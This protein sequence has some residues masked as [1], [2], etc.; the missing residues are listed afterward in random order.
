MLK[1]NKLLLPAMATLAISTS[2]ITNPLVTV[3]QQTNKLNPLAPAIIIKYNNSNRSESLQQSNQRAKAIGQQYGFKLKFKRM[4]SGNAEVI[5]IEQGITKSL[6]KVSLETMIAQ[7]NNRADIEYAEIDAL[8]V[9]Y[10]TPNDTAYNTQ[11]H[12]FESTGGMRL[13]AAWD[14]STGNGVTVAVLDTGYRPHADLAGNVIGQ[15]DMIS[16]S[17]TANDGGGRDA[18]AQDPGDWTTAGQ[19]GA[20]SQARIQSYPRKLCLLKI[21]IRVLSAQR[22]RP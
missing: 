19:C 4:M 13:P 3:N 17:S 9:P 2:A 21:A 11:W 22:C 20:G 15:Y 12:Y 5:S 18:N 7:L 16:S 8:M 1:F 14:V 6:T 10:A